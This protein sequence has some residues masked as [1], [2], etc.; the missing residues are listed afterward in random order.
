M[1]ALFGLWQVQDSNL[2]RH[3]PA[4][5]QDADAHALTCSDAPCSRNFRAHSPQLRCLTVCRPVEQP[6]KGRTMTAAA[7]KFGLNSSSNAAGR[8][9]A[10]RRH[11]TEV[12]N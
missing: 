6:A 1:E 7:A 11:T 3:T 9:S 10:A 12:G 5:L 8:P 2:R 4:D